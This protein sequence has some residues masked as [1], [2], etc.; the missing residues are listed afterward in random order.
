MASTV[1]I[2]E[3][4]NINVVATTTEYSQK[5][6]LT[7][8]PG[9][10][11]TQASVLVY[12]DI[13]RFQLS[14]GG[15]F[16]TTQIEDFNY[17][18]FAGN[19]IWFMDELVGMESDWK[20]DAAAA[21]TTAYGY[22]QF[23]EATVETAVN[24]YKG[25]LERFNARRKTRNWKP[26]GVPLNVFVTPGWLIELEASTKTHEEK[27][28]DL[29]YDQVLALAFVHLHSK[30]SKDSNFAMLSLGGITAAKEIYTR[31]HHTSPDA[32]TLKRLNDTNGGFFQDHY[33]PAPVAGD[34]EFL[35]LAVEKI[36]FYTWPKLKEI[37]PVALLIDSL[38]VEFK[39]SRHAEHIQAVKE[40]FGW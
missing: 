17:N 28:D 11:L 22:V 7:E 6:N 33:R 30:K 35:P 36:P 21:S 26:Y 10:Y 1:S 29:T 38:M 39:K 8:S 16:T 19:I 37:F 18:Q 2:S 15:Y 5:S 14:D 25:H 23:T 27:L 4:T 12:D 9:S 40:R 13:L 20:K 32:A 31:N 34:I 3:A 24:R